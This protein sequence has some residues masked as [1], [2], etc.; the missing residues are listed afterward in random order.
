MLYFVIL[1]S[2]CSPLGHQEFQ[3]IIITESPK[4]PPPT[5]LFIYLAYPI[6]EIDRY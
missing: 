6:K 2:A 1:V 4:K 5:S 3:G